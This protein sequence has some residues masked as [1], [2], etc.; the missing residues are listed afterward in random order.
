MKTLPLQVCNC[1]HPS[2]YHTE[3]GCQGDV[4]VQNPNQ[5]DYQEICVCPRF[6]LW[7]VYPDE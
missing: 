4:I 6:D 7:Y 3:V 1:G 2:T 5:L